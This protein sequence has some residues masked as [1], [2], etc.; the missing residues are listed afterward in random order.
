MGDNPRPK[1][2]AQRKYV[3]Q[4]EL[5]KCDENSMTSTNS[6][7][8]KCDNYIAKS[9]KIELKSTEE[10]GNIDAPLIVSYGNVTPYYKD[11]TGPI[12]TKPSEK[13]DNDVWREGGVTVEDVTAPACKIKDA[14]KLQELR[15]YC[16]YALNTE[17]FKKSN[18]STFNLGGKTPTSDP[19]ELILWYML[20]SHGVDK[21]IKYLDNKMSDTDD[22]NKVEIKNQIL[23]LMFMLANTTNPRENY[24]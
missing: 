11:D 3:N 24:D 19:K 7:C 12:K 5:L 22:E 20:N 18:Y 2:V 15:C 13:K 23:G 14:D 1:Y 8:K 16:D 4:S 17:L 21:V 10:T 6:E 9:H